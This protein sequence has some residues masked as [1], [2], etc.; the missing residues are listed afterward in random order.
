MLR[1]RYRVIQ[2]LNKGGFG[3]IYEIEDR[4]KIKVLKVLFNCQKKA[5]ELFKQEA[6]ILEL[7]RGISGFPQ[8]ELQPYFTFQPKGSRQ[9]LHCL[10]MEKIEGDN[11]EHWLKIHGNRGITEDRALNWLNQ[12][13]IILAVLHF[14]QY[15][16][17]DIKPSNIMI[18]PNGELVLIDLG[19]ARKVTNTYIVDML[20]NRSGTRIYSPDYCPPEQYQGKAVPQSDYFALGRTFV[21][22]LTGEKLQNLPKDP[23]TEQLIWRDKA[24]QISPKLADL[25]DD[26]M[27]ELP[28]DRPANSQIIL[29]RLKD[30]WRDRKLIRFSL[31]LMEINCLAGTLFLQE[32]L[33]EP[34]PQSD[35]ITPRH[36]PRFSIVLLMS[37]AI[38]SLSIGMRQIGIFQGMELAA[39][40]WLMRSRPQEG[41]DSRLLVVEAT[42]ADVNRYGFPLPD[43]ILAQAVEKLAAYQPRVIGLDIFRDRPREPG[44]TQLVQQFQ[45]NQHLIGLCS[46]G[47]ANQP[48]KPGIPPPPKLP[49]NRLG[50]SDVVRD[51]DNVIRRHLMFMQPP[52]AD[53]CATNYALSIRLA[54]SYLEAEG[55][56]PENI[57]QKKQI[58]LGNMIINP[59]ETN[60]GAYRQLDAHGFQIML[61]Y[62][63]NVAQRLRL[64]DVLAG[65]I[66]PDWVKNRVILIGTT[67][68]ISNAT[69]YFLTPYSA[70]QWPYESIP[71]VILQAQMVSQI[72]SAVKDGRPLLWAMPFWGEILWIWFWSA[73]GGGIAWLR[74][75][76]AYQKRIFWQI[77]AL[78]LGGATV[79]AT[80]ILSGLCLGMLILGGW[81]PLLP[82]ALALLIAS[83]S[84]AIYTRSRYE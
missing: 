54:L 8:V 25:I 77:E 44:Y 27:A 67:A 10:V 52:S 36:Q 16:H 4:G 51:P 35:R 57:G 53:P 49:K 9:Q 6:E 70:S 75:R 5:I 15:F 28:S 82:S 62:R 50:F 64:Q 43:G 55:I 2:V 84:V 39:F 30:L 7:L 42:E 60:T 40:D 45:Q 20:E 72:L 33:T 68:P 61:N 23:I 29:Q 1:N 65:Q 46:V 34:S 80:G 32:S 81:M 78:Y 12:I 47:E 71:G 69:D 79:A 41:V 74:P 48:N 21:Y 37:V 24:P 14:L 3:T 38:A 73:I 17:R 56:K 76:N 22:L 31:V 19:A 58:R 63:K 18:K 66:N 83:G 13:V 59:L 26:L 11:L